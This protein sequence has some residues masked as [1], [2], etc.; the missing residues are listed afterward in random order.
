VIHGDD[1]CDGDD[2]GG[3]ICDDFYGF[4]GGTLT[5]NPD[6]TFNTD[7]CGIDTDPEIFV[8]L[9]PTTG[10]LSNNTA[11]WA[12]KGYRITPSSTV[13]L[14]AFEWWINHPSANW[15]AARLYNNVGTLLAS[16]TQIYGAGYED[17]HRSDISYTLVAGQ[18]YYLVFYTTAPSTAMMDYKSSPS[19]PFDVSPWFTNV[20]SRSTGSDSWPTSTNWWAPFQRAVI[21]P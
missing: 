12:T 17:W 13:D 5:C 8:E 7:A 20:E 3:M 4:E 21:V 1:E 14:I 19:M 9:T 2:L 11:Y 18:T 6:C 10:T 15:L 16:G